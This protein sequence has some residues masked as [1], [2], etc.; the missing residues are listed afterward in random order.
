MKIDLA[1]GEFKDFIIDRAKSP[2]EIDTR[3]DRPADEFQKNESS[4][5]IRELEREDYH[6]FG[7]LAEMSQDQENPVSMESQ[8]II[9]AVKRKRRQKSTPLEVE[10]GLSG[11]FHMEICPNRVWKEK[12]NAIQ[13]WSQILNVEKK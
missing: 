3:I 13:F 2:R 11:K 7:E 1:K 9:K 6:G 12:R 10:L 4:D 8:P 5:W